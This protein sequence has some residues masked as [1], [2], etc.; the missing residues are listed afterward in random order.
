MKEKSNY[1][2]K[3]EKSYLMTK[4]HISQKSIG[5]CAGE[6]TQDEPPQHGGYHSLFS[7]SKPGFS[8]SQEIC[9]AGCP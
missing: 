3:A 8:Q 9:R 1:H 4:F 5:E 6:K 7:L 2:C